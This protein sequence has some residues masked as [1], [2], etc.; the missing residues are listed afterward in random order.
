[1]VV[2]QRDVHVIRVKGEGGDLESIHKM[3][4][5]IVCL[6][7]NVARNGTA[8]FIPGSTSVIEELK[9]LYPVSVTLARCLRT[10]PETTSTS[11]R[12]SCLRDGLIVAL[13]WWYTGSE[14]GSV[15]RTSI[16]Y[17]ETIQLP[18][19]RL[20]TLPGVGSSYSVPYA[21]CSRTQRRKTGSNMRLVSFGSGLYTLFLIHLNILFAPPSYLLV[22]WRVCFV[23]NLFS[24]KHTN[25]H[26][27]T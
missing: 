2:R 27:C 5:T 4:S 22:E 19:N 21:I 1:M 13:I 3:V 11:D 23:H 6:S 14:D 17:S 26:Y 24:N 9:T 20:N 15:P 12:E 16:R 18:F 25:N 8:L 10:F 7:E